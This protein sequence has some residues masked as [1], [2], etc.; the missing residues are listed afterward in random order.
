MYKHNDRL[1]LTC[2][3]IVF[4]TVLKHG[5]LYKHNDRPLLTCVFAYRGGKGIGGDAVK[6]N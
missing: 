2:V 6:D 5:I 3:Y 1:L 4:C